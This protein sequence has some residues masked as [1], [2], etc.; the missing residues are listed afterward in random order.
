MMILKFDSTKIT[1]FCNNNDSTHMSMNTGKQHK[2]Y[3]G[4]RTC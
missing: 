1:S 2:V 3:S 4:Q